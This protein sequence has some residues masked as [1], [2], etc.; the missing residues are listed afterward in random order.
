MRVYI[1]MRT[2]FSVLIVLL[3]VLTFNVTTSDAQDSPQLIHTL[4]GHDWAV[5]SVAFSPDS[6]TLASGSADWTA[7]LWDTRTGDLRH[8][9]PHTFYGNARDAVKD[10]AFSPDGSILAS[11][12][13]GEPCASLERRNWYPPEQILY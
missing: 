12:I 4:I 7:I 13:E 5:L 3:L 6:T 11:I 1:N 8:S 9:L 2:V 10:V